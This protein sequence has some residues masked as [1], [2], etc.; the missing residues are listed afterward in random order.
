MCCVYQ[1]LEAG[2]CVLTLGSMASGYRWKVCP[3]EQEGATRHTDTGHLMVICSLRKGPVAAECAES[4][5]LSQT[6]GPAA[7][8]RGGHVAGSGGGGGGAL[9]GDLR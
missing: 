9:C 6:S 1:M 8:P 4:W 3:R 2:A 5:S 7:K